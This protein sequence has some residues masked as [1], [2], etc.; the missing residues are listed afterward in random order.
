M[1]G[2]GD[3]QLSGDPFAMLG[4]RIGPVA[5]L[6]QMIDSQGQDRQPI[7]RADQ[8]LGVLRSGN[9]RR[10]AAENKLVGDRV[11]ELFDPVVSLLVELIDRPLDLGNLCVAGSWRAGL[12]FLV[13]ESKV[14]AK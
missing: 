5:L 2:Q 4:R 6:D 12:V 8:R 14:V 1:L 10:Y 11:V 3:R 9:W 13:P 7:E